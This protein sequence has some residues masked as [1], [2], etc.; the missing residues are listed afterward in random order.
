MLFTV[1]CSTFTHVLFSAGPELAG[2]NTLSQVTEYFF[3]VLLLEDTLR[4]TSTTDIQSQTHR[5]TSHSL[6]SGVSTLNLIKMLR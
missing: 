4:V 6:C 2:Q 3:T 5:H 1:Y